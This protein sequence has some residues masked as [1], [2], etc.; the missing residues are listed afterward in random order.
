[1]ICVFDIMQLMERIAPLSLAEEWD[2]CGLQIGSKRWPVKKIW[3]A[4]DPLLPV[5]EAAADKQVDMVI[6]H[7]PL[8]F[9]P[10]RNLDV[11]TP[12]GKVI[13][14]A[15]AARIAVYAAHTCLDS[16]PG[17]VND[18]LAR[19]IGLTNLKALVPA[20]GED[21]GDPPKG[22]GRIGN[23]PAPLP[24][25]ELALSVKNALGLEQIVLAGRCIKPIRMVAL[26]SGSG[27]SLLETFLESQAQV[28]ISGDMHYHDARAVEDA[29][30]AFIDVGHFGSER[31]MI[32]ALAAQISAICT[33]CAWPVTIE[34]CRVEKN[35]FIYL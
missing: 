32:D 21:E 15:L 16:A 6:T 7:H 29:G 23:L 24:L 35:P 22:L 1:M 30:R 19:R 18:V 31:V 33:S 4:L 2:N 8:F 27:S 28:Y 14:R 9:R 13:E 11:D 20:T 26:C 3:V 12:A 5:I 34:S 10:L 17:G 25:E